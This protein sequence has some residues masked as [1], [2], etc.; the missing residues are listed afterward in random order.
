MS[1]YKIVED[2][3]VCEVAK[4]FIPVVERDIKVANAVTVMSSLVQRVDEVQCM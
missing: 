4:E 1:N 3:T 2:P